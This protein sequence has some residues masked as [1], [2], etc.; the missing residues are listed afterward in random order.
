MKANT[1]VVLQTIYKTLFYRMSLLLYM[2]TKTFKQGFMLIIDNIKKIKNF[3][4]SC[5]ILGYFFKFDKCYMK[6]KKV[7]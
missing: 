3:I 5:F 2:H 4:F 1:K 7:L 6:L